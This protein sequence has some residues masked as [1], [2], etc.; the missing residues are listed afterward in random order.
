MEFEKVS[1]RIAIN[2][3]NLKFKFCNIKVTFLKKSWY[4]IWNFVSNI[5]GKESQVKW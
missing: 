2:I 4:R 3:K 5:R 1:R